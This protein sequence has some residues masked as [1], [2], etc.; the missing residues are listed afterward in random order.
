MT[1]G[2]ER[3]ESVR[4]RALA[5]S[6]VV[7][8]EELQQWG[9]DADLIR[10]QVAAG[11]WSVIGRR[12]VVL[13]NGPV[14][15]DQMRWAAVLEGG[16]GCVLAG[17]SALQEQGL[18]GYE[19]DRIQT[20][21]PLTGEAERSDHVVRRRCRRLTE[22]ARHPARFPPQMRTGVALVDALETI[23]S[24]RRGAALLAAVVQ[25]R[26]LRP[27]Q[28]RPLI[29]R[30]RTLPGR[31]L[32]LAVAGD[33][34]GGAHSLLEID[35]R[36]LARRAGLP[37]PVG[38]RM[39]RDA[40]GRTRYLDADFGRFVVEVDGA[41]HLRPLEWWNDMARQN[42]VVIRDRPMLR[43]ASVAIRL[44]QGAV[45]GQLQQAWHRFG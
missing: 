2:A 34:E 10:N 25:Q 20:A 23:G 31:R 5:T 24:R 37:Q 15:H 19:P 14:G 22:H 36:R 26:L 45:I 39:R 16:E 11:R 6:G 1:L 30:E 27:D 41:A 35:F 28:V 8:R 13:H 21:V 43:F 44:D 4:E 7:S 17:L 9:V 40:Q 38:Q 3:S 12:A 18:T 32:Y 33:I 42:D 29:D